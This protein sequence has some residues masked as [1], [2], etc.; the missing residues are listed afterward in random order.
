MGLSEILNG[1]EPV[2]LDGAMGTELARRGILGGGLECLRNP[3]KVMDIHRAYVESGSQVIITNSLTMNRIYI[4]TH[5]LDVDVGEVNRA[6][7]ELARSASNGKAL[8]LGNLSSTG[9]M[10][11]PY[12]SYSEKEFV[13]AFVEQA[14][15]LTEAGVDGLVIET[16][17]DLQEALCAVRG[18]RQATSLPILIL[19]AFS[20][21]GRFAHTMMGQSVQQCARTLAGSGVAAIGANC[22]DLDPNEMAAVIGTLGEVNRLPVAVEPNAGKPRLVNGETVFDMEPAEFAAGMLSC[23]RAGARLLGGCCGT[24]PDHI[25]LLSHMK[26][27]GKL[28]SNA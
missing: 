1:G 11:A 16:M 3:R 8:V 27:A 5:G 6:S 13:A 2:L 20:A 22:G 12:G 7:V 15:Y 19:M 14:E 4:D 18:C 26:R 23:Y 28:K 24:T 21:S 9:Q 25:R 17:Y 10:L